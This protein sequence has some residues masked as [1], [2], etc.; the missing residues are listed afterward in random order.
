MTLSRI[1]KRPGSKEAATHHKTATR[2]GATSP[3]L[4]L[5]GHVPPGLSIALCWPEPPYATPHQAKC[6]WDSS[7]TEPL[8]E[9]PNTLSFHLYW[10][11]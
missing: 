9:A 10:I 3:C 7:S 11:I 5:G 1:T 2:G 6:L 4:A 8:E